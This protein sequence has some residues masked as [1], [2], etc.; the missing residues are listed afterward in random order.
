ML[1]QGIKPP[2]VQGLAT[3]L[4]LASGLLVT[5]S[6]PKYNCGF[7]AWIALAP[8]LAAVKNQPAARAFFFGWLSGFAAYCGM[9][10]WIIPTYRAANVPL[11]L[12]ILSLTGLSAYLALYFGAF[13]CLFSRAA[14]SFKPF[15]WLMFG[16]ALWTALEWFRGFFLSGFPWGALGYSQWSYLPVIQISEWLGVYGVSAGILLVNLLLFQLLSEG[17]WNIAGLAA[18]LVFFAANGFLYMR[19]GQREKE[20]VPVLQAAILQGNIDQYRKWNKQYVQ[21]ILDSYG[22]LSDGL[23]GERSKGPVKPD[24]VV[25]PETAAPGWLPR[26]EW[27]ERWVAETV[28]RSGTHHLI[29][30]VTQENGKSFN[31]AFLYGPDGKAVGRYD[32]IRLVPFGEFVPAQSVLGRWIGVL[33]ELGGFDG[34]VPGS[35]LEIPQAKLGPNICY[36]AI[37]PELIR[38]QARQ[39]AQV[40]INMTN[41]GWYLNT[42]AP[43]QHFAMNAFRAVENRRAVVRAANTGISGIFSPRGEV[44]SKTNLMERRALTATVPLRN[45]VTFY[46]RFGNC[47]AWLCAGFALF[48]TYRMIRSKE[49]HIENAE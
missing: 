32:K 43:A 3:A 34:G 38:L 44:L 22:G 17:K 49:T 9:L 10:F 31:S 8:V 41:D 26:E 42:A 5:L 18:V 19:E 35:L 46:S 14:K 15:Y 13:T 21:D 1:R 47:F 48:A 28:A 23:A 20:T 4:A 33:N 39:G 24:L 25:W 36:E 37:F 27:L 40:L 30:A 29:G 12:G 2:A 16:A 6:F 11:W 45:V 7:L